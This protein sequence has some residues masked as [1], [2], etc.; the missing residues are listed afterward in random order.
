MKKV[1][2]Q[3]IKGCFHNSAALKFFNKNISI[4][5]CES[6]QNLIHEVSCK[7][8]DYGVIAV[9]NSIIGNVL[10]NYELILKNKKIK[11]IGDVYLKIE[12]QLMALNKQ[13]I[14][15]IKEVISHPMAIKQC[16]NFFNNKKIIIKNFF[17]TAGAAKYIYKN[18]IFNIAAIA[19][20]I[21]AKMYKLNIISHNIEDNKN[22]FTKFFIITNY[23]TK[24]KNTKKIIN[25]ICIKIQI[26]NK[27]GS[28][29]KIIDII[30][31]NNMNII[32]LKLINIPNEP[33]NYYFF[34]EI[35]FQDIKCYR[36]MKNEINN[37][38]NIKIN[39]LGKYV[40]TIKS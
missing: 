34:M 7:K 20:K 31:K 37:K 29:K 32:Q 14:E 16:Q 23:K 15:N 25:K 24:I 8:V 3:G 26:I 12:H 36:K 5:T 17:D 9:E 22:N 2:I 10:N 35:I 40:T 4:I 1:A 18:K 27:I 39:I 13:N 28:L 33:W 38:K 21:A 6:F 30:Y 19:P 11:I